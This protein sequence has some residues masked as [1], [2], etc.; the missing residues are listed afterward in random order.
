MRPLE[1][2]CSIVFFEV[3]AHSTAK[4]IDVSGGVIV[5]FVCTVK[6]SWKGRV[7]R[8]WIDHNRPLVVVG[9]Q[10]KGYFVADQFE[11]DRNVH[12]GI[13]G[14]PSFWRLI[15]QFAQAQRVDGFV[16]PHPTKV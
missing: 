8:P 3:V 6:R 4:D 5:H 9:A 14:V 2:A 16:L 11:F 13:V 1:C 7:D 15:H 10:F 12:A